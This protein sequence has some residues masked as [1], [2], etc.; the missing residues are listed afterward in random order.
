MA[1]HTAKLSS[2]TPAKAARAAVRKGEKANSWFRGDRFL[3]FNGQWY[4]TIREG[5]D[6]G[7]FNSRGSAERGL[8]LF[9]EYL[10]EKRSSIDHAIAV[11]KNG[12]WAVVHYQ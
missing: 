11:A 1:I 9:I 2:K 8:A 7:P 6:I 12:D 3:Q 4:F 10:I 5:R